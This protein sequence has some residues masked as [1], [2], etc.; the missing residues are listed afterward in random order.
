MAPPTPTSRSAF[1]RRPAQ[2]AG[3]SVLA[4]VPY[5]EELQRCWVDPRKFTHFMGD[6]HVL[7][8]MQ[9]ALDYGFGGMPNIEPSEAGLVLSPELQAVCLALHYFLP[10]LGGKHLVVRTDNTSVVCLINHQGNTRTQQ[11]LRSVQHLLCWADRHLLSLRAVLNMAVN[12]LSGQCPHPGEW[13]LH[14]KVVQAIW[15][16][17]GQV[18]FGFLCGN[19]P[20]PWA[21]MFWHMGGQICGYTPSSH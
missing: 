4:S 20:V 1:F 21:R 3:F 11:S 8:K 6:C 12:L 5:V 16:R 9:N 7:T 17:Y 15:H 2:P 19:L 18:P 14:P 10:V 13:K